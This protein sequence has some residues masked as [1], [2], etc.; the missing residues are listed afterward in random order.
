MVTSYENGVYEMAQK[1]NTLEVE[2]QALKSNLG[3]V[4]AL[5][6]FEKKMGVINKWE[7]E[8]FRKAAKEN[9]Q[10]I[11]ECKEVKCSVRD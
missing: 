3:K 10:K 9:I 8:M 11:R 1:T 5:K 2:K 7:V 6:A 4:K